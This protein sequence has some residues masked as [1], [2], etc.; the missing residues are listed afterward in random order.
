MITLLEK[1]KEKDEITYKHSVNVGNLCYEFCIF[2]GKSKEY[3]EEMKV[4]GFLHDVGKLLTP[5]EV[6]NK[7]GF[8][9]EEEYGIIKSHTT[10]SAEFLSKRSKLVR[11]VAWGHHLS[12]RGG[13][14]PNASLSGYDIPE[15]C[16]IAA[17]CDVF[18]ALTA[19]RQ[20]KEAYSTKEALAK[21]K[22]FTQFDPKLLDSFLRMKKED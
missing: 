16:R 14:Y 18:E 21:M 7:P 6:L 8:L 22:E 1:I 11:N 2:L 20:Y 3:A 17:I 10:N 13:G 9:T 15:E 19:K 5:D 12:F 4:A